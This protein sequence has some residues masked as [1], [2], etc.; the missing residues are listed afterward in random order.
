LLGRLADD[1]PQR[2]FDTGG[3]AI[4]FERTSALCIVVKGYLEN[5]FNLEWIAPDQITT[6][7]LDLCGDSAVTIVLT[8]SLA[9]ADNATVRLD[10]YEYEIFPPRRINRKAF[11]LDYFH[12]APV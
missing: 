5:M 3:R 8:V 6:K 10:A 12:C 11:D 9:P 7:I 2:L 4:K 1:V